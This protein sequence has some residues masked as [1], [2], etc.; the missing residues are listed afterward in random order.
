MTSGRWQQL[1]QIFRE[2]I[3]LEGEARERYLQSA[4][5]ANPE[6]CAEARRLLEGHDLA[7]DFLSEPAV[8][9]A[10][11]VN[12]PPSFSEGEMIAGRFRVVR[13]LAAGGMGEV[14]EADDLSLG[15]RVALK[16]I[17]PGAGD[18]MQL[19]QE[20]LAARRVSHP[21]VCRIYDVAEH[22]AG[23]T[24]VLTMELVAGPTLAEELRAK[25]VFSA[26]KALPVIRQIADA[27]QAAHDAGV[28]HRD[29]KLAN[30]ILADGRPVITDFGLAMPAGRAALGGGTP[31]YMPPEQMAGGRIT[32]AT[33]VYAFGVM[34]SKMIGDE[35]RPRKWTKVLKRCLEPNP[36]DR[37]QRPAEIAAAL[38]R[39][40]SWRWTAVI[41][42][43]VCVLAAALWFL[44]SKPEA[45][46]WVSAKMAG[47][48]FVTGTNPFGMAFDG[49][50][51][52]I[53]NNG[54]NSITKL[55]ASDGSCVGTCTF[56][57]AGF[58]PSANPLRVAYDG[59]NL[60]V[61]SN[62]GFGVTNGVTKIRARDGT[63]LGTYPAGGYPVEIAFDGTAIWVTDAVQ[64]VVRK[65]RVSDGA[66]VGTFPVG[67]WPV[68]LAFDGA[69][70]WVANQA[71]NN[72]TKL[73][74]SD[75]ANL[76]TFPAGLTPSSITFDGANIWVPNA[77]ADTISKV[78][79]SDGAIVGTFE[80]GGG[81][82]SATFDGEN[83]W[84]VNSKGNS[85]TKLRA[86]DGSVLGIFPVGARPRGIVFD[87]KHIWV[88]N[89]DSGTASRL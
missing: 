51:I 39:G 45:L 44:L 12:A 28:I 38:E 19:K 50:S 18:S 24:T 71:S 59:A 75:G 67:T 63:T 14:Y 47:N 46:R 52:W 37:Y 76:G 40:A 62:G 53:T 34:I 2:G 56:R 64:G 65:L 74:A 6:L 5:S 70:M 80:T 8:A 87:G 85:V 23:P 81:P 36:A 10:G 21:N 20:L 27:L 82:E 84:I 73:R 54:S 86:S 30:V 26:E 48:Q 55:R 42:A 22:G 77:D 16:A 35:R 33:D 49:D 61:V 83:V 41:G 32:P 17:R 57:V 79:A 13:F 15:L 68:G 89:W 43:S 88:A 60:W 78:R 29:L 1:E 66:T 72:M 69:N 25:G 3:T 9:A 58:S 4:C 11:E 31:G 7:G